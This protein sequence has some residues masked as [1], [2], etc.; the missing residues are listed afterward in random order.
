MKYKFSENFGSK[1]TAL[2]D[3]HRGLFWGIIFSWLT[4]L[5]GFSGAIVAKVFY[6][7]KRKTVVV[8]D[9]SEY[10]TSPTFDSAKNTEEF[11]LTSRDWQSLELN[12]QEFAVSFANN[13][14]FS[15]HYQL[16][17]NIF[18]NYNNA[19]ATVADDGNNSLIWSLNSMS[20]I[21]ESANLKN[22]KIIIQNTTNNPV[23]AKQV[24]SYL[25]ERDFTN[26]AIAESLPFPI[27]QTTITTQSPNLAAANYLK[28][29]LDI[30][31]LNLSDEQSFQRTGR[32]ELLVQLGEDAK[33]FAHSQNFIHY[34]E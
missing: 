3:F 31:I 28:T 11:V 4:V 32:S 14:L 21:D 6:L 9:R 8:T 2:S 26:I 25:Q 22:F 17:S 5:S 18:F 24:Y 30:G 20:E 15:S 10:Q 34:E 1:Y 19:F 12:S 7:D 13:F 29:T 23:L 27:T 33:F 16:V